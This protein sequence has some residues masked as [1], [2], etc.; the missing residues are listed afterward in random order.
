MAATSAAASSARCC[1][2]SRSCCA[3]SSLALWPSVISSICFC[4]RA[5]SASD[6]KKALLGVAGV[7]TFVGS[8]PADNDDARIRA[9]RSSCPFPS[10][11]C[12]RASIRFCCL[13]SFSSSAS[14][15]AFWF[16]MVVL[17]IATSRTWLRRAKRG[18][19]SGLPGSLPLVL[20]RARPSA[21]PSAFF[22]DA[23]SAAACIIL[24][25]ALRASSL[26]RLSD[27]DVTAAADGCGLVAVS[28]TSTLGE[29]ASGETGSTAGSGG[30]SSLGSTD[31]ARLARIAASLA[32]FS[33]IL[34]SRDSDMVASAPGCRE[35]QAVDRGRVTGW[36]DGQAVPRHQSWCVAAVGSAVSLSDTPQGQPIGSGWDHA[37][38][39]RALPQRRHPSTTRRI[40]HSPAPTKEAGTLP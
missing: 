12:S 23:G 35:L 1:C 39:V 25:L 17:S 29:G 11:S 34:A 24:R 33:A 21:S 22:G 5:I 13:V 31:A 7:S 36:W 18:L 32:F 20:A 3:V 27:A 40:T 10:N 6:S 15:L 38:A 2:L 4:S 19:A 9:V 8:E 37:A 28:A 14:I 26:A 30:P 16:L